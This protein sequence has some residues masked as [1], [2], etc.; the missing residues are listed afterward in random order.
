[1]VI[2]QIQNLSAGY[3]KS[4]ILHD[5]SINVKNKEIVAILGPN[6]S[7]KSTLLKA[8]FGL[9]TIY[10][11]KII[12]ENNDITT[13]PPHKKARIGIVY[14]PQT[15]N[16]F[17]NL[18][19]KENLIMAGYTLGKN[20]IHDRIEQIISIFPIIKNI[21]N[22]KVHLLSGGERQMLAIAMA[23]IRKPKLLMFDEP[24]AQLAPKI[25]SE[26]IKKIYELKT[27]FNIGILLVEQNI[28]KALEIC[29]RTYLLV[30]GKVVYE[31][32]PNDLLNNAKFG[33]LYLG[34][35]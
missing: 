33:K 12:F 3:G 7:G 8:I 14:L 1:M 34:L 4:Q 31:G 2:L 30:N 6:G 20:E 18:T 9:A 27:M 25:A 26:I 32:K 22:K 21:M 24:T 29:D 35:K 17:A 5:V 15:D 19:V 23:L 28:K 11:G 16:C 13:L 10:S